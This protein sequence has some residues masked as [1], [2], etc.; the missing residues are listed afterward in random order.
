[1]PS[2]RPFVTKSAAADPIGAVISYSHLSVVEL[3]IVVTVGA[4]L[5]TDLCINAA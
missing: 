5:S 3:R 1:L 4:L 2:P